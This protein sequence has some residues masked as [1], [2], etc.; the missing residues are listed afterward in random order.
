MYHYKQAGAESD[1]DVLTKAKNLQAMTYVDRF[2]DAVVVAQRA[3]RLDSSNKEVNMVVRRTRAVAMA[4]SNEAC[5]AYGE[6]L[7]H[8]PYNSVLLCNRATCRSKLG[9][10]EKAIKNWTDALNVRPSYRKA[11]LRRV[12][13]Y[14]KVMA[15]K[16]KIYIVLEYVGEGELFD[17]ILINAVNYC[18]S[19]GMY[20]RDLKLENLLLD[21]FGVL[22][23]S[24]FGLSAFS[25]QVR[26]DVLLHTTC[27]TPNYVAPEVL[28]DKGYDGTTVDIWSCGVILFVLMAGYLPFDEPNHVALKAFKNLDQEHEHDP[29][30][31]LDQ[32]EEEK[33]R[34]NEPLTFKEAMS[35]PEAPLWKE[36]VNSEV[37][38]IL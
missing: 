4:R 5:V 2:D 9:Q 31:E 29:E 38:F 21:S 16:T 33:L 18:H 1:P 14:A 36:A 6:G 37:E 32:N 22:K 28:T 8:D 17:K 11:R 3:A 13:C 23:V 35:S 30:Q 27:G 24:D 26:E 15:S 10:F 25:Q 7:D 20:H 12:N 19:R 34:Q